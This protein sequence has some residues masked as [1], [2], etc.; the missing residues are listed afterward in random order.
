[1][2]GIVLLIATWLSELKPRQSDYGY[3]LHLVAA[4]T[5]WGGLTFQSSGD[6]IG[7]WSGA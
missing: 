7:N 5:I 3:W 4:V 1:M 2:F 6:E